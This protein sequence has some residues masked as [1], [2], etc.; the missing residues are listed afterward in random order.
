M[1]R[2]ISLQQNLINHVGFVFDA[3]I[4]MRGKEK[5]LIAVTDELVSDLKEKSQNY[6]QE[7]RA[8]MYIF[9]SDTQPACYDVDV[10]RTPSISNFYEATGGSTALIDATIKAIE[11]MK[12]TATLYGDHAF[13]LYV[14][15]D[16]EENSSK[17]NSN[18]LK[19]LLEGLPLE[20]TAAVLVPD[21]RGQRSAVSYGFNLENTM[22]W[23]TASVEGVREFGTQIRAATANYYQ[24]R[25]QGVRGTRSLFTL[26]TS[27]LTASTVQSTLQRLDQSDYWSFIVRNPSEVI[28]DAVES[29]GHGRYRLGSTFYQLTKPEDVQSNKQ[30]CLRNRKGEVFT[31][32]AARNLLGLP[33][34]ETAR[35]APASTPDYEIF[36]QSTAPNRK[37][38]GGTTA[39]VLN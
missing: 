14:I 17:H 10:L 12:K 22:I 35:V 5:E 8:T 30:V 29:R 33:R 18:E 32:T 21:K 38:I 15:T 31:G 16:G 2:R 39:I 20:W 34:N 26:D 4:S 24:A 13:L 19:V 27:N 7:T 6:N 23:N 9:G 1:K 3:S 37:L 36:V 28:R 25:S 11:D